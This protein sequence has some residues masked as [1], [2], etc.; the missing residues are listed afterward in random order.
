LSKFGFTPRGQ[1]W[2]DQKSYPEYFDTIHYPQGFWIPDLA[3]FTG[4]DAKT[5]YGR[6]GKLLAQVNDVGITDMHKI[7][8]FPLS[9]T[10][11]PLI[12]LPPYLQT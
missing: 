2:S 7:R 4:D 6:I 8:M 9:P 3:K 1:A 11:K 10:E 5:T 12:G